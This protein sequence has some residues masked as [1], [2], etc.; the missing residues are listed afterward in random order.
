MSTQPKTSKSDLK[1][2]ETVAQGFAAQ[3][4]RQGFESYIKRLWAED[5][6]FALQLNQAKARVRWA[7]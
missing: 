2:A 4:D 5:P 3:N 7:A 1:D 6:T